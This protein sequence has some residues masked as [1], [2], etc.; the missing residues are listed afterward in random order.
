VISWMM[1]SVMLNEATFIVLLIAQDAAQDSGS[2]EAFWPAVVGATVGGAVSLGTT[3]LVERQRNKAAGKAERRKELA[4]GH[5]AARVISLELRD[6][7]SVLRVALER[8]PFS[9][10]PAPDFQFGVDAW[11]THSG[12][13]GAVLP[14]D[15]WDVVAAAY[16]SFA[17]AN[18]L[19]TVNEQS[20]DKMLDQTQS[21]IKTLE[22]WRGSIKFDGGSASRTA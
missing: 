1:A 11:A 9:W 16:S 20:A 12:A 7:E 19:G 15:G 5:L 4:G 10:P 17:Y 14:D 22:A 18:L 2:S 6:I 13:L 3:L 21:S 8:S